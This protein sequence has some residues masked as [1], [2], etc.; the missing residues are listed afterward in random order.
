MENFQS[1]PG[2]LQ[3]VPNTKGLHIFID[4]SH[5]DDALDNA[6]TCLSQL[7]TNRLFTV[8]GCGGNRDQGK[9][10]KMARVAASYSDHVI[11]TSD[12]PRN[13]DPLQICKDIIQGFSKDDS[14]SVEIDRR[15]AIAQIIAKAEKGDILLIAGK[16]HETYQIFSHQTVEFD[17]YKV[18]SELSNEHALHI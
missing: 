6:L 1:V 7:K 13:E 18:A 15:K 16:G 4:F 17:D 9:R 3:A 14:F 11:V 2:R 5:T 10:P 12:N 8:F